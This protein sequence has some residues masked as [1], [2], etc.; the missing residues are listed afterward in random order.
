MCELGCRDND[1]KRS[2]I[3]FGALAGYYAR[4]FMGSR[5]L[6]RL[7]DSVV[8]K[9]YRK[10]HAELLGLR[11]KVFLHTDASA[12]VAG[13]QDVNHLRFTLFPNEDTF[14]VESL[15]VAPAA[16]TFRKICE[17][18]NIL[19]T[20]MN[21]A[22]REYIKQHVPHVPMAPGSYIIDLDGDRFDLRL[23]TSMTQGVN[24]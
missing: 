24:T 1:D 12:Q 10:H 14:G 18:L 22:I 21:E 8:P 13:K 20:D 5:G 11:K 2:P 19:I 6:H 4:P 9:A 3:L 7:P 15:G 17:L 23:E 16:Q